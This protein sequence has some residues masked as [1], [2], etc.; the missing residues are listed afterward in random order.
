MIHILQIQRRGSFRFFVNK[1]WNVFMYSHR[2]IYV[3]RIAWK[4]LPLLPLLT[5]HHFKATPLLICRSVI[6][7]KWHLKV[8]KRMAP[9]ETEKGGKWAVK[10][11]AVTEQRS[12]GIKGC[13]WTYMARC[14]CSICSCLVEKP[15]QIVHR[16]H[17]KSCCW[18]RVTSYK[19]DILTLVD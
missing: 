7:V 11:I 9:A 2:Q 4:C 12:R 8:W 13:M 5:D 17:M 15:T 6:P 19:G 16:D 1:V 18:P 10:A 3:C 14:I